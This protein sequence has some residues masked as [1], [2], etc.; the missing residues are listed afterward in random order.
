M[1]SRAKEHTHHSPNLG[2]SSLRHGLAQSPQHAVIE[3][4]LVVSRAYA[5]RQNA[6]FSIDRE[7][8][9]AKDALT[10]IRA[11]ARRELGVDG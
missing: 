11:E 5:C 7:Y 3:L 2:A 1:Q 6:L 4:E 9:A 10:A 8:G